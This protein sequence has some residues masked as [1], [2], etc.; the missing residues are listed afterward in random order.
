[1]LVESARTAMLR[2]GWGGRAGE[3]RGVQPAGAALRAEQGRVMPPSR[4]GRAM[5]RCPHRI[6]APLSTSWEKTVAGVVV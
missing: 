2:V 5:A 3:A 6:V 1:M 4:P